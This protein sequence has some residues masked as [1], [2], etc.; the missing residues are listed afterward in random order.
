ML[1]LSRKCEEAVVIG[2][3]VGMEPLLTVTVLEVNGSLVKLGFEARRELL[4][5]RFE[6]W[7]RLQS[8]QRV[9]NA[10]SG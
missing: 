1:V 10:F 3:S 8:T 7:E 5:H 6:V 4:I 9:V 2:A